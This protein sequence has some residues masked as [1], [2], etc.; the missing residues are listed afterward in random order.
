[1]SR[2]AGARGT[3][4]RPGLAFSSS[5]A[6]ISMDGRETAL[7]HRSVAL[8]DAL[9]EADGA[10][11]SKNDLM[12]RAWPKR[13][14]HE[15]SLAK[16]ISKLR[17]VLSGSGL[18]IVT[19]HGIGYRLK[20]FQPAANHAIAVHPGPPELLDR[21]NEGVR[22]RWFAVIAATALGLVLAMTVW[23]QSGPVPGD[24][25]AIPLRTAAPQTHDP[26]NAVGTVLWVDD[27]PANNALDVRY[28]RSRD[29]AVHL[30]RSTDEAV[31]LL[32]MNR[33][34]LV[35]SDLGRGEN[36][37]AG[38]DLAQRLRANAAAVPIMIYTIRPDDST[39]QKAQRDLIFQSGASDLALTPAEVRAKALT[40]LKAR[41]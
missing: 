21:P 29:I 39:R 34:D 37:L 36:R 5:A 24:E 22:R 27:H 25:P 30:A 18:E 28:L 3:L 26:P 40:I 19:V 7:D 33:Y 32:A 4:P 11:V 8:L 13:V 20:G 2:T 10:P 6:S 17:T 14:L 16:A 15:N 41:R 9:I 12:A 31:K 38:A 35:I 23:S 1:M